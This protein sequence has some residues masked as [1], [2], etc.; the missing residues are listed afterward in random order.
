MDVVCGMRVVKGNN[1]S[2]LQVFKKEWCDGGVYELEA[3]HGRWEDVEEVSQN[4]I[5]E[6]ERVYGGIDACKRCG[7]VNLEFDGNFH[8]SIDDVSHGRRLV[9]CCGL[10]CEWNEWICICGS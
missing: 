1:L 10:G 7:S 4:T 2:K 6:N 3:I 8:Y 9:K 5:H